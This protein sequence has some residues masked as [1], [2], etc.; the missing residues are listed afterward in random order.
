[1]CVCVRV[2]VRAR[3]CVCVC[4]CE[5]HHRISCAVT[6]PLIIMA[7]DSISFLFVAKLFSIIFER[8]NGGYLSTQLCNHHSDCITTA[9]CGCRG[10]KKR[11]G[12]NQHKIEVEPSMRSSV[13]L[14]H[15]SC[16]SYN[17]IVAE[18]LCFAALFAK[19]VGL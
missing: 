4:A 15:L 2:R 12:Q 3:A 11:S 9:P 17:S 13:Q 10:E 14:R 6:F 16:I 18:T 8:A 5:C 19:A 7:V 1:M